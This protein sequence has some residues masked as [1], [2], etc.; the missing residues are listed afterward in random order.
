MMR[1]DHPTESL[2]TGTSTLGPLWRTFQRPVDV[3]EGVNHYPIGQ[4]PHLLRDP[5]AIPCSNR[6]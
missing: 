4:R 6:W 5:P 1:D 3:P 2:W